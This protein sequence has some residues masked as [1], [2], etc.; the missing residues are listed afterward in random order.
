MSVRVTS[1]LLLLACL[2]PCARA[3]IDP[4]SQFAEA[5]RLY[6]QGKFAEA[7]QAYEAVRAAGVVSPAL[8]FNLG[9]SWFKSGATGRAI[10]SYH[11][12]AR[13]APRDPDLQA[14]LRFARES[15]G[16]PVSQ[17]RWRQ[18]LRSVT[19]NE[20][21]GLASGALWLWLG[22]LTGGLLQ[23]GAR[24][25]LRPWR[26]LALVAVLAG[27]LLTVLAWSDYSGG[28]LAVVVAE[29]AVVRYGPIEESQSN[30]TL[31]DGAEVEVLDR[32]GDWLQ[33]RDAQ[34]R[35]G[36]VKAPQVIVPGHFR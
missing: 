8:W 12:A 5:S 11:E 7:A 25:A 30:Y 9:N 31:R 23:P 20:W 36:W 18:W 28:K 19:L 1:L 27:A 33:V 35:T 32:N 4:A 6:E 29:E 16:A 26:R 3:A 10:A 13:L 17:S 21:A 2:L 24:A 15:V 14:N 34:R 22:L